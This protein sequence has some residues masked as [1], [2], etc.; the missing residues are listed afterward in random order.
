MRCDLVRA[1]WTAFSTIL[2]GSE[3]RKWSDGEY[4]ADIRSAVCN[5]QPHIHMAG[6]ARGRA[7]HQHPNSRLTSEIAHAHAGKPRVPPCRTR[8]KP[9]TGL[10]CPRRAPADSAALL[11]LRAR[12]RTSLAVRRSP[13]TRAGTSPQARRPAGSHERSEE[14]P[15]VEGIRGRRHR[16]HQ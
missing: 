15:M 5:L 4:L 8:R 9:P 6:A 1:H 13:V 7:L 16:R 12:G 3:R 11:R 14:A 10:A 2:T